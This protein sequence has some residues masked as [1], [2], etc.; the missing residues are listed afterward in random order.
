MT[1]TNHSSYNH[2]ITTLKA[3]QIQGEDKRQ[4]IGTLFN[5]ITTKYDFLRTIV[6]LGQTSI[7]YGQALGD[8]ELQSGMKVLDVGCGTEKSTRLLTN[9]YL[10]LSH[11]LTSQINIHLYR[12]CCGIPEGRLIAVR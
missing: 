10:L 2:T 6:F 3:T 1:E 5:N 7:R 4:Y 8:L 11:F 12:K 9:S